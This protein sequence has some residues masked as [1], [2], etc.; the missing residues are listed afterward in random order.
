MT[1][2]E[3]QTLLADNTDLVSGLFTT[4]SDSIDE[5]RA[6]VEATRAG[7]EFEQL[8]GSGLSPVEKVLALQRVPLFSRVSADETRQIA[9]VTQTVAMKAA[10][11]LF[12]ESSPPALWVIL[13]GEVSMAGPADA[14]AITAGA[15]DVIGAINVMA[16]RQLGRSA[17]VL[18]S[19]VA[20]RL[21]REDL[22]GLFTERP[23]LL[24]QIFS[25]M[26]KPEP[27]SI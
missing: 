21:D 20:L 10:T 15:G 14:A 22:F 24:R 9:D 16:G 26:F 8:A 7:V 1:A 13:A 18:R 3:L 6:P 4:L 23:E 19:G 5:M 12:P 11:T 25:G 17:D 2:E 27:A